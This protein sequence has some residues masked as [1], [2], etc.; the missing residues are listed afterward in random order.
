[1]RGSSHSRQPWQ[2]RGPRWQSLTPNL[3]RQPSLSTLETSH[4]TAGIFRASKYLSRIQAHFYQP[5]LSCRGPYANQRPLLL[6]YLKCV[7]PTPAMK[8]SLLDHI[9]PTVLLNIPS[10]KTSRS[11]SLSCPTEAAQAGMPT[12][13]RGGRTSTGSGGTL[14]T[15][16]KDGCLQPAGV[17]FCFLNWNSSVGIK[18]VLNQAQIF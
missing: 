14:L 16:G 6:T 17:Y 10:I 13:R 1:M 3:V 7:T 8:Y 4:I 2:G 15:P 11:G 9:N 5:N 18:H 12:L